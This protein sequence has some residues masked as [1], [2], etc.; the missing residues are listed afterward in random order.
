MID[1]RNPVSA[2][3]ETLDSP[4]GEPS[5]EGREPGAPLAE[6]RPKRILVVEDEQ[7][8]R[9]CLRMLLEL[10]GYQVTEA[11]NGAEALQLFAI[12]EFHLVITDLQMPVMDGHEL[13]VEL[14]R[15][16][17]SL[18]MLM[19]TASARA[20]P[21]SQNP[22]DGLLPKPFTINELRCSVGKLWSTPSQFGCPAAKSARCHQPPPRDWKSAAVSA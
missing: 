20:W 19:V 17:P 11:A 21:H 10:D 1:I 15:L 18:P 14:K 12:G 16:A 4:A 8:V 5:W 9:A 7:P 6:V 13:A 3:F 2:N 22:V